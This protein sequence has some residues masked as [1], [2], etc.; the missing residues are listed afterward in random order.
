MAKQTK[1][2][3][4][5]IGDVIQGKTVLKLEQRV[6][7][8]RLRE[9]LH[10]IFE[11]DCKVWFG[12]NLQMLGNARSGKIKL[13]CPDCQ[14][15]AKLDR[16]CNKRKVISPEKTPEKTVNLPPA[17]V[18]S[19]STMMLINR[20]SPSQRATAERI[21]R[22]HVRQC[23]VAGS[24]MESPDRIW[25]EAAEI[26]RMGKRLPQTEWTAENCRDG[27]YFQRYEQY[28]SPRTL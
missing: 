22:A 19:V 4:V 15:K 2:S 28:A 10:A 7:G 17:I 18:L 8:A 14:Y 12:F 26:A 27:L 20:L 11:C 23:L 16:Q 3:A 1:K 6:G 13:R 24:P 21:V 9:C 5:E 25:T